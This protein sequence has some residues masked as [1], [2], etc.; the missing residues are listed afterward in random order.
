[1][2]SL[3]EED[4]DINF[5]EEDQHT[6]TKEGFLEFPKEQFCTTIM[7]IGPPACGKTH[8]LLE[9]LKYWI[10]TNMFQEYYLVL[11][12][13]KSEMSG[14]YKWLLDYDN[15]VVYESFKEKDMRKVIDLAKQE[16][17]DF[18]D[19]KITERPRRFFAIDDAT[20]QNK[21]IFTSQTMLEIITQ[22]RHYFIH[23]WLL[24]HYDKGVVGKK[25]RENIY[26][27]LLYP[28]KPKLLESAFE[29]Y[30]DIDEFPTFDEFYAFWRERVKNKKYGSLLITKYGKG[31]VNS[32]VRNWFNEN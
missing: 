20:S 31:C 9:S 8:N 13:F 7:S 28:V 24:L 32:T 26:Y 25:S 18:E 14:S 4:Y 21:N 10:E 15:V 5:S 12:N 6:A 16:A 11:P 23:S 3:E 30:L 19:K 29:Q 27:I 17:E 2:S 1:M 22:N